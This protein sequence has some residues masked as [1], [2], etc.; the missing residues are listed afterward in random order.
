MNQQELVPNYCL[1]ALVSDQTGMALKLGSVVVSVEA[2]QANQIQFPQMK[3]PLLAQAVLE[4]SIWML[5][6]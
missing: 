1:T 4:E 3:F 5:N 2:S 6:H